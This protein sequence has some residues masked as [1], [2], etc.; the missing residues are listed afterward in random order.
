MI[1]LEWHN[2][3]FLNEK[4]QVINVCV[5]EESAHGSQLLEDIK[6]EIGATSV[7]CC[8]DYGIAYVGGDWTGTEFRP[9][10]PYPSWTWNTQEKLWEAPTPMP[11]DGEI[12]VWDE[13]NQ[14]WTAISDI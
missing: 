13:T 4:N 10:S 1:H 6:N 3:A 2:H 9:G 11:T 14:V 5:F 8:C 12:Y 7:L